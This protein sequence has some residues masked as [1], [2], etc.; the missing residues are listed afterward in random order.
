MKENAE[1]FPQ[2]EVQPFCGCGWEE[3]E[4]LDLAGRSRSGFPGC[5]S[6]ASQC[7]LLASAWP[8]NLRHL[9]FWIE[10]MGEPGFS[11]EIALK[12]QIKY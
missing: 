4:L 11:T 6:S 7:H 5:A 12:T 9:W 10:L 1:V 2:G 8:H 3:G